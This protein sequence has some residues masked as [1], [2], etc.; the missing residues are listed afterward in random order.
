MWIVKLAPGRP[1]TFLMLAA[2]IVFIGG[3]AIVGTATDIM[4]V[5]A[6]DDG[7]QAGPK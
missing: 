3:Y 7:W 4:L 2:L 6:L 1:N 5:K